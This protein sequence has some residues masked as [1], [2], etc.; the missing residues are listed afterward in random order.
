MAEATYIRFPYEKLQAWGE[1]VLSKTSMSE[2]EIKTVVKV[3]LDTNLRGMDTHGINMLG[4]YSERYKAIEH[5]D[6]VVAE[7][8]GAGC[9]ID[10]G[11]HTGQMTSMFALDKA[12][13]KAD[14][15][16][17]GLALVRESCHN[18]AVGYYASLA[19]QRGYISLVST[20]VMP[21]L[22]PWGGLE[23]FVGNNPY[24]IGFPYK[25]LPIVL[26][27]ANTVTA[28]QKIF[29][30]AREGWKLPDGWAMDKDGNPT[31][32]PQEAINGLLMPVGG[33]KGAGLALMIDIILG[34]LAGGAYG[35]GICANTV[36]DRAQHIAH[37]FFVMNPDFYMGREALDAHMEQY[38]ADFRNVRKKADVE[39]LL[40]P[41]E[42][43]WEKSQERLAN[44]IPVST[45]IIKELNAYA[46][47][48]GVEHLYD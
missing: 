27:V 2:E 5:R 31:N 17:I 7:D 23:P 40:L 34:T 38:V 26:D 9:I 14:K 36:T 6:I 21:L 45:A 35:R 11:N 15:Y 33:H 29:S 1:K 10:G 24:A 37:L 19:A 48:I 16:G 8:K 25:E 46:D 30:Y 32:D 43:E 28:R 20:T 13:E 44:G 22:A 12:I 41:G 3:L 42:L 4:S 47:K 18:G 39:K